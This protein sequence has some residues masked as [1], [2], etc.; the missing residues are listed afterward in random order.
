[1]FWRFRNSKPQ[2]GSIKI[3]VNAT[4]SHGTFA[5]TGTTGITSITTSG[6]T[7]SQTAN[8]NPGTY[9][10]SQ[11]TQSNWSL[12]GSSCTSGT[13]NA[14]TITA[15]QTTTCT[16]SNTY[17]TPI[18]TTVTPNPVPQ[19]SSI[20]PSSKVA[21]SAQ[22]TMTINGS[23]F[24]A[25]STVQVNGSARSTGLISSSQLTATILASD[26]TTAGTKNITVTNPT[27]GGGTSNLQTFTVTAVQAPTPTPTPTPIQP[28]Q[29]TGVLNVM[30]NTTGSS[31]GNFNFTGN[32]GITLV[33]VSSG[34][35]NTSAALPVGTYNLSQMLPINWSAAVSC[36]NGT[37]AALVISNG[38][39]TTCTF[40]NTYAAPQT[41]LPPPPVPTVPRGALQVIVYATDNATAF[42]F[43]GNTGIYSIGVAGGPGSQVVSL[44]PGRCYT[45]AEVSAGGTSFAICDGVSTPNRIVI[46]SDRTTTCTFYKYTAPIVIPVPIPAFCGDSL[47]DSN[48]TC[49]DGNTITGDGC[50]SVCQDEPR[51]ISAPTPT[52][53]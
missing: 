21:G 37:P 5:F 23:N 28:V 13:P 27:P 34:S 40:N 8:I 4:N 33:S 47:T 25:G 12:T 38:Q 36:T 11:A 16:F 1:M 32:T 15:G 42:I 20:S 24:I 50:S 43:A 3:V 53:R 46:S 39:T 2:E 19:I 30:V 51:M 22:F 7:G 10:V 52:R 45:F 6:G 31:T 9:S 18:V 49:D 44:E 35:G 14:I 41:P 48:E 26:I 29:P 17:T